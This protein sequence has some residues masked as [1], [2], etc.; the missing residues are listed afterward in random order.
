[1]GPLLAAV[2]AVLPFG[3]D[4]PASRRA[5]SLHR[6]ARLSSPR[7]AA[8]RRRRW[9]HWHTAVA[10][11]YDDEGETACER[12]YRYGIANLTMACGTAVRLCFRGCVTARVQDRGPYVEGRLFDL[13]PGTKSAIS[14]TDLCGLEGGTLSWSRG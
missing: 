6:T 13:N 10:S 9:H 1:M 12:H 11:W 5:P 4:A 7:P 8:H 3:H 2:L 14:C